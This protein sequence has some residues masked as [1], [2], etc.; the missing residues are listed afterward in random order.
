LAAAAPRAPPPARRCDACR[1]LTA[2]AAT[3]PRAG[4]QEVPR[5]RKQEMVAQVFSSVASSYDVMNDLMSAGLH[6]LW[7]DRRAPAARPLRAA[8]PPP[9]LRW[10]RCRLSRLMPPPA[11]RRDHRLL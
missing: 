3:P 7:K 11:G 8:P 6:R 10:H 9:L 1:Q 5:H 2:V 4:F